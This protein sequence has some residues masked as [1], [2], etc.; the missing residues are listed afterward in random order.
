MKF[1]RST[2][3]IGMHIS[4]SV[5]NISARYPFLRSNRRHNRFSCSNIGFGIASEDKNDCG[6]NKRVFWTREIN[7]K[8]EF[9][10]EKPG[11]VRQVNRGN[12]KR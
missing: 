8:G 3:R 4:D 6:R 2:A 9:N 5:M 11:Q 10:Y 1:L 7:N 12:G